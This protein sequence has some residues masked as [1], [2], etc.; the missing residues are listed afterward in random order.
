MPTKGPHER[1]DRRSTPG[2]EGN[3]AGVAS[4]LFAVLGLLAFLA[5]GAGAGDVAPFDRLPDR[6]AVALFGAGPGCG[7]LAVLYG[8]WGLRRPRRR[9]TAIAGTALGGLLVMVSIAVVF[10]LIRALRTLG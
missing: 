10:I 9:W 3:P 7:A 8:I 6:V 1:G 5:V 2:R 4:L